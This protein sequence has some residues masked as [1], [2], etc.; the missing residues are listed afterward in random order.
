MMTAC[1]GE[2][3]FA[4]TVA[5][6]L[7]QLGAITKGDRRGADGQQENLSAFDVDTEYGQAA[8]TDLIEVFENPIHNASIVP[9]GHIRRA[10]GLRATH[11]LQQNWS[12]YIDEAEEAMASA[13]IF[14][15]E[16]LSVRRFLNRLLG[17]P[18]RMQNTIFQHYTAILDENVKAAKAAGR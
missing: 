3:R 2:R 13:G 6:R 7:Q 5:K 14:G 9:P 1:G 15:M 11:E 18:V 10:I 12:E 17:M 4:S 8:L 16:N